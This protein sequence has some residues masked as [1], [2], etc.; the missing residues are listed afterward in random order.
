MIQ[1]RRNDNL[2]T[3]VRSSPV[4]THRQ[5]EPAS[6]FDPYRAA[7]DHAIEGIF[8]MAPDGRYLSANPALARIYGFDSPAELQERLSA[9]GAHFYRLPQRQRDFL[10]LIAE[11]GVVSGFESE[12]YRKDGS[13]IWIS[14]NAI[15]V[16]DGAGHLVSYEGFVIDISDRRA[17]SEALR[18]TRGDLEASRKELSAVQAQV[19][20]SER[21]RALGA[22]VNGI[23]HDF[24]NSLWTILGYG[25]LLQGFCRTKPVAPE[26]AEYVAA[27]V[28]TSLEAVETITRLSDFQRSTNL[29]GARAPVSLNEIIEK[30]L[31]FTRP[32]WEAEARGRGTPIEIVSSLGKLEPLLGSAADFCELFTQLILNAVEAMRQGGTITIQT[33][34]AGEQIQVSFADTGFG[35]TP[36][37][38]GR[39]LEPF[40]TTKGGRSSGMGLAMVHGTVERSGGTLNIESAPGRGAKFIFAFPVAPA[41]ATAEPDEPADSDRPL[42]ILAVDDH[43][44]Q[45]ELIALALGE[46][47]HVVAT[48]A[49]GH[50]AIERFDSE[51][52]DLVITDKA[53]PGMS[54]DQL[55]AAIKAREPATPVIMLTGLG[56]ISD[57]EEDV[58][59]FVDLLVA[60]PASLKELR[61]AIL[62]VMN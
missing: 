55:A 13:A 58:S 37:V 17:A 26:F 34:L 47:R 31:A 59:E 2:N 56:R 1:K 15:S 33:H 9:P 10:R 23:A 39:C 7:F 32:R 14:E 18:R 21:L 42:R 29:S 36:E 61:A 53:M 16:R 41:C 52:F 19:T 60:K 57:E 22:M 51:A 54:G 5:S 27:I 43:P 20:E 24:N 50:D 44:M 4:C 12:V 49:N 46:D 62:K 45:T 8:Q 35:M 28:N 38:R 11:D 3:E 6:A 48:A 30:A 25:E 40:F